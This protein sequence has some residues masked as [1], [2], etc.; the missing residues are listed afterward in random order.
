MKI[1]I[2]HDFLKEYG[3]AERVMEAVHELYP[4]AP[5]Y[6]AFVDYEGLGPHVDRIRQWDV[7]TTWLQ[8]FPFITKLYSPLRFL[9]PF[10]FRS[11]D[12]SEY[13]VIISS[14]NAYYAKGVI[15]RGDNQVHICYCHTPPRSLYG[16]ATAM[17]WKKNPIIRAYGTFINHFLRIY[18][19]KAAQNVDF[20][21]ANSEEVKRRIKKF[22]RRDS[23]VIYPPVELATSN[24]RLA[25]SKKQ[26]YYLYVGKLAYAKHVD[27]AI[28]AANRMKIP[29]KIV[30]KGGEEEKLRVLAGL[31]VEFL[32]EV[33]DEQLH[34]LYAH[35]RALIFT[36]EDEDFG[37][38]PVEAMAHGVPVI[39]H[40]SGGVVESVIDG[41]TGLFFDELTVESLVSA[42]KKCNNLTI[43]P[44]DCI[45]QAQKFSKER[46]H[47]EIQ[48]FVKEKFDIVQ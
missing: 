5:I 7:R 40:R 27:L 42:I 28:A 25:T 35:S 38:V 44:S 19:F 1:A 9:A 17:D 22:Y 48:A 26:E 18:D 46:F 8:Q 24:W 15:K 41:K 45:A 47:K 12:L 13:D 4:D 37:I 16:Y 32:G 14:T 43:K 23:V 10:A 39:A 21:I 2:V 31:T 34:T 29:L 30:G 36:A 11:L 3:G 20:F 6:T 33:S